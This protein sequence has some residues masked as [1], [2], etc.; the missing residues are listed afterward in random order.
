MTSPAMRI[1]ALS[2][3]LLFKPPNSSRGLL[4]AR[5]A[6]LSGLRLLYFQRTPG[7]LARLIRVHRAAGVIIPPQYGQGII[8]EETK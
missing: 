7:W 3:S 8:P 6:L 4:I 5:I 1:T 2:S